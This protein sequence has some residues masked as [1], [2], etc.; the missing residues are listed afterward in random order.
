MSR[1]VLRDFPSEVEQDEQIFLHYR[2]MESSAAAKKNAARDRVKALLIHQDAAGR[3]VYG[4]EDENGNRTFGHVINGMKV[5][6]QRKVPA[7]VID[8]EATEKLLREKGGQALYDVVFKREVV[9]KFSEE[10]LFVLN[11]QGAITDEE[12][13]ALEVQGAATYALVAVDAR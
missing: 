1:R 8:L 10:D 3:F 2:A 6:A 13:D 11:Q 4:E 5:V 7:P 12:L 9:R